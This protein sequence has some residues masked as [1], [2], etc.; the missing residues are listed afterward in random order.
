MTFLTKYLFH[1]TKYQKRNPSKLRSLKQNIFQ[2]MECQ[3]KSLLNLG[4]DGI[5]THDK[6][7]YSFHNFEK[8]AYETLKKRANGLS[9][10]KAY[11]ILAFMGLKPMTFVTK[12][13]F[14]LMKYQKRKPS[15]FRL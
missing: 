1:L 15:K 14:Q 10:E 11:N 2:L 12:Y 4:F 6:I 7:F 5:Q 9:N 3:K 8:K 13:V